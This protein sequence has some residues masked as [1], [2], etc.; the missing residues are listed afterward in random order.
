MAV[1]ISWATSPAG[2]T[3]SDIDS[4][5]ASNGALTG[6]TL[7]YLSHDHDD[8]ITSA[9]LFVTQKLSSY[10]GDA[11][12]ADDIAEVI[13]WG[14]GATASS[15]GGLQINL[16]ADSGFPSPDGDWGMSESV[17]STSTA[18]TMRT[19]V[20]DSSANGFTIPTDAYS[21]GSVM[22]T[23]GEIP[24]G[25]EIAFYVRVK[26]PTDEGTIGAREVS[27]ALSYSYTP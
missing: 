24:E 2:S 22:S 1:L 16:D 15:F 11:T 17:K 19:G 12:A 14:D 21:S 25:T 7:I 10:G 9:K 8:V 13:S 6:K 20:G 27:L 5:D 4:G 3:E 18:V 26:V 23:P